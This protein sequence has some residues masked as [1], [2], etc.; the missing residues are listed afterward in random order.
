MRAWI[1]SGA[2]VNLASPKVAKIEISPLNTI[3]QEPGE[4]Q[5]IRVIA[6]YADGQT[7]DVTREAYVEKRG[8]RKLLPSLKDNAP[9]LFAEAKL[10][11]WQDLKARMLRQTL[12]VMGKRDGFQQAKSLPPTK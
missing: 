4:L 2:N 5:Q 3:V 11:C 7:R 8:I 12:T 10:L 6:T 1:A 9:P